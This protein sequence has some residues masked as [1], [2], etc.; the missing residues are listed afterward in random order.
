MQIFL[1]N[2]IQGKIKSII[3]E[4]PSPTTTL[5]FIN[6]VYFKGDWEV[7]FVERITRRKTFYVK[8]NE[9]L[10]VQMMMNVLHVPFLDQ[11]DFQIAGIPYKGNRTGFF[12]I[13]PKTSGP[14]A[15]DG[16]EDLQ[17]SK[18]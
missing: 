6:A 3:D 2:V 5:A 1:L 8:S 16:I 10:D 18:I 7:P 9:T 13:L 15:H 14:G 12:V 11:D 17:V 4:P